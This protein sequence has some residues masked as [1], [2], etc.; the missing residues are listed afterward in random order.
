[1]NT[2]FLGGSCG[3]FL[4]TKEH[5]KTV[6]L[7][8]QVEYSKQKFVFHFFK[9]IFDTSFRPLRSFCGKWN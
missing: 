4:E 2:T 6:V 7:F 1:M 3:K 8:F 5:L 9:A